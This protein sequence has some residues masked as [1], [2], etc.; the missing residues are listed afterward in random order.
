MS[1]RVRFVFFLIL[2]IA[3][4][5]FYKYVDVLKL[6]VDLFFLILV[7]ISVKSGFYKSMI[8]ATIIGLVTDYFSGGNIGVFGFSRTV[9][10]YLLN[11]FSKYIDIRRNIFVFFLIFTSLCISN[12]IANIFFCFISNARISLSLVL[13]QPAL[14]G[15][16]G[17]LI[18]SP[19][20]MKKYFNV[21]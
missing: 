7:Y 20:R 3:Q 18:I 14:T 10:A 4:I 6:N 1:K 12:F 16:A 11:Q 2:I 9:S 21:Y 5:V 13:Y 15:L 8:S 17:I 19:T